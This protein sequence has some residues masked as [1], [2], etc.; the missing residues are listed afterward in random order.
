[1]SI[2]FRKSINLGGGARINISRS[3]VGGSIGTTGAR[4]TKTANG[5][6]RKT[7][8]I[9]GTGISYV[10]ESGSKK[11]KRKSSNNAAAPATP[12][13]TFSVLLKV[14]SVVMVLLGIL[15]TL[16]VPSVGI[17]SIII[18]ICEWFVGKRLSAKV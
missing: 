7:L 9:A 5:R 8:S 6:T 11:E 10:S 18:G 2:R 3:G 12:Y 4:I 15:L 13:K 1:M 17:M 14:A 16:A